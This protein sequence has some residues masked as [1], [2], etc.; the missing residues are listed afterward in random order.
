MLVLGAYNPFCCVAP[1]T[2]AY[3]LAPC[4]DSCLQTAIYYGPL[5]Y[6]TSKDPNYTF[7]NWVHQLSAAD[8]HTMNP[9]WCNTPSGKDVNICLQ[10]QTQLNNANLFGDLGF[11]LFSKCTCWGG[12]RH[13]SQLT[14][15]KILRASA[16]W[17]YHLKIRIRLFKK[18]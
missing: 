18:W 2:A 9:Y 16:I 6:P 1:S 11:F 4:W 17:N 7:N 15:R 14:F 8:R 10:N 3:C 12:V 5:Y 13:I